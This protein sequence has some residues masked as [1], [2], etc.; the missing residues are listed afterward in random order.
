M[1]KIPVS[2][3]GLGRMGRAL[4]G[5]LIAAGHPTTVWNRTPSRAADLDGA[6]VAPD[7]AT[8]V[9][10]SPLVIVCVLDHAA[11]EDVLAAAGPLSDAVTVVNLTTSTPSQTRALARRVP[12]YLDGGIMAIPS[13]IATPAAVILYSGSPEAFAAHRPVLEVLGGA[14]HLGADPGLA[15]LYDLALLAAMYG[16]FGGFLHAAALVRSTGR[17][18]A[19]FTSALLLPWL[20]AM[21]TAVPGMAEQVDSGD[22]A[23]R[24]ASLAMQAGTDTITE[25]SREQGVSAELYAPMRALMVRAVAEGRGGDDLAS[26]VELLVR[27]TVGGAG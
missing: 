16:M 10:A 6:V 22:Y 8:A 17:P 21:L 9:A 15:S 7:V 4:A 11:V 20:S 13:L 18:V 24:D 14:Q 5:A 1:T 3:L 23:A 12:S 2:V 19:E 26:V 27:P 25:V